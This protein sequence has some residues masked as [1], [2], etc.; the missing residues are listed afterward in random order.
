MKK[1]DINKIDDE[2]IELHHKYCMGLIPE[3][4]EKDEKG[5]AIKRCKLNPDEVRFLCCKDPFDFDKPENNYLK[6][7]YLEYCRHSQTYNKREISYISQYENFR[8]RGD[9]NWN[10]L[11]LIKTLDVRVCPY[12]GINYITFAEKIKNGKNEDEVRSIA[13]FDHYLPKNKYPFLAMNI[14]NLIP[15]CKNCNMTFKR[16]C[17]EPI[18]YPFQD[19]VES[20]IT[21]DIKEES[22]IDEVIFGNVDVPINID[23]IAD[24]SE[25]KLKNHIQIIALNERYNDFE[26]LVKSLIKKRYMYNDEYLKEL[27]SYGIYTKIQLENALIKQDILSDDEPFSKFKKDIWTKLSRRTTV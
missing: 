16:D 19:A 26:K 1:I 5:K 22:A 13:T 25:E 11:K 4:L 21:F 24:Y 8:S 14:Y 2:I 20:H 9:G 7:E 18:I 17:E 27:E 23:I 3:I 15:C 12:C 6:N 10:G